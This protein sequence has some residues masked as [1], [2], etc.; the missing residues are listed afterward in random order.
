MANLEQG[1]LS[2]E[3]TDLM[4]KAIQDAMA[5]IKE[6]PAAANLVDQISKEE[7]LE[8]DA[9]KELALVADSDGLEDECDM[10]ESPMAA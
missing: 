7:W 5:R 9:S 8:W 10:D 2:V 4:T 6:V 3:T 1:A